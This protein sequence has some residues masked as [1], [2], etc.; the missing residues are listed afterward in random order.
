MKGG[1]SKGAPFFIS[2]LSA[3]FEISCV[4]LSFSLAE[5]LQA[6][7]VDVEVEVAVDVSQ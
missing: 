3:V 6:V 7:A 4:L 1:A 5:L 2:E